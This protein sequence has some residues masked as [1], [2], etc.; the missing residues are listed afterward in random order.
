MDGGLEVKKTR[1][2]LGSFTDLEITSYYQ[3]LLKFI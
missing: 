1:V 3:K 2:G